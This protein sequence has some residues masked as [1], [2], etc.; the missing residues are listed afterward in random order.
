[1]PILDQ[2]ATRE[3]L[4]G[5]RK[6]EGAGDAGLEG[7]MHLPG[8]YLPLSLLSLAERI[9]TELGQYQRLVEGDIVQSGDISTE[10]GLVV[11]VDV[12]ADEIGK[13]DGQIFG[14]WIIGVTD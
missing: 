7:G 3:P 12:E 6:D 1:S 4:V 13:V 9:Y 2:M 11:Q 8:Q 5:P 14:R 10:C